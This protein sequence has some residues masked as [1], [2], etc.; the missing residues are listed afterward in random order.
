LKFVN[1]VKALNYICLTDFFRGQPGQ[2]GTR[3][4]DHS[5]L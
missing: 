3:M 1:E 2:A 4:A 5:G